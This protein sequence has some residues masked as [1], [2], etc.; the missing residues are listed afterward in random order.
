[1]LI[2]KIKIIVYYRVGGGLLKTRYTLKI[3]Y[4]Q[5]EFVR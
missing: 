2:V 1:M 5:A 3:N 4:Q